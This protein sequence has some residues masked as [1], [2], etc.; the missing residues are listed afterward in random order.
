MSRKSPQRMKKSDC[1]KGEWEPT[2]RLPPPV[3]TS[4]CH[5]HSSLKENYKTR[6]P[7]LLWQQ[8]WLPEFSAAYPVYQSHIPSWCKSRLCEMARHCSEHL[9]LWSEALGD[10]GV[11]VLSFQP[12]EIIMYS[13]ALSGDVFETRGMTLASLNPSTHLCTTNYPPEHL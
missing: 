8:C 10:E 3:P 2:P 13:M 11:R 9:Q 5:V 12:W 1:L 6:T 4:I 7:H